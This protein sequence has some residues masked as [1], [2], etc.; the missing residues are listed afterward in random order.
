MNKLKFLLAGIVIC[1]GFSCC[2][3]TRTGPGRPYKQYTRYHA[4]HQSPAQHW[5]DNDKIA[6]V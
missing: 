4:Y 3:T 1:M 6:R 2:T 5:H